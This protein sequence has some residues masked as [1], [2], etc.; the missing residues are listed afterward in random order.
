MFS[1]REKEL[2]EVN[3]NPVVSQ[4]PVVSQLDSAVSAEPSEL[5]AIE[6]SI[7][8]IL[9]DLTRPALLSP[10]SH[11]GGCDGCSGCAH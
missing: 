6:K 3:M 7:E 5:E 1:V 4:Q 10:T 11:C 2:Q 9:E 8:F